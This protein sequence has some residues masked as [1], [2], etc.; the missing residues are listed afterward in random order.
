[1]YGQD[2]EYFDLKSFELQTEQSTS[3]VGLNFFKVLMDPTKVY[4]VAEFG[5]PRTNRNVTR[6]RTGLNCQCESYLF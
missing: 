3:R 1:M 2:C 5:I 6:K 4:R